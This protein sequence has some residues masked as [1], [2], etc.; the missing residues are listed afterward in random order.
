MSSTPLYVRVA[1]KVGCEDF[2]ELPQEEDGTILLSTVQAQF[3]SAIGLKYRGESGG[4]RGL[5]A[6][7]NILHAP[8]E[9]WGDITFY[10]T[11]SNVMKRKASESI[12]TG[13]STKPRHSNLLDD[14][15]VLGVPFSTTE[16]E[17]KNYFTDQ[18][19]DLAFSELKYE[20]NSKKSRG[21]GF[22]RFKTEDGAK[23]ALNRTHVME[24]RKLEIRMSKKTEGNATKLFIGRLPKD[25]TEADVNDYFSQFGEVVDV[26]V[27]NPFRGF[28]F[29]TYSMREEAM[30]VLRNTHE[31][32]NAILNVTVAEPKDTK[33]PP[34]QMN[35][36]GGT[37]N[38]W[39]YNNSPGNYWVTGPP[40][41]LFIARL[42][43]GTTHQEVKEYFSSYGMLTDVFLPNPPR[44]F[45][46][47]TYAS[48]DDAM[49]VLRMSHMMN[50]SQLNVSPAE[51]KDKEAPSSAVH[52]NGTTNYT[53]N[54]SSAP[55]NN[56]NAPTPTAGGQ[57]EVAE[58]KDMLLKLIN[59]RQ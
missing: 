16:E 6:A 5:K 47:V 30:E 48:Q 39:N 41:K 27:P 2:M 24:G 44:G 43:S 32:K 17:F 58:I 21:F 3:P 12:S 53:W 45:C 29:V 4:W 34:G 54:P 1:E 37:S 49:R 31:I 36:F 46:F 38:N 23:E 52:D 55:G 35:N 40:M 7:D 59:S 13:R 57:K 56:W 19:G 33:M 25:A 42:P 18:C 51:P 50:G 10:I 26:F 14:I 8:H 28:G 22:I 9:G 11:E 15:I 20:R